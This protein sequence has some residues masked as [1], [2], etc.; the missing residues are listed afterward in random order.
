MLS[1]LLACIEPNGN[2]LIAS[3][4]G[5]LS[6]LVYA[7]QPTIFILVRPRDVRRSTICTQGSIRCC[8][9]PRLYTRVRKELGVVALVRC[10]HV[11]CEN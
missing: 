8:V 6:V 4:H 7:E 5:Q 2:N 11:Y 10:Q 9:W 3:S 1:C